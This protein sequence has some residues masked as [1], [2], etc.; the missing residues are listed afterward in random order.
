MHIHCNDG[1]DAAVAGAGTVS[2]VGKEAAAAAPAAPAAP[3]PLVEGF[4]DAELM[5]MAW[6]RRRALLITSNPNFE[7][8]CI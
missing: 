2:A 6:P 7:L 8:V 4:T 1:W 5:R 3:A